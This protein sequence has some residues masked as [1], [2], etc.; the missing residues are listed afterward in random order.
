MLSLKHVKKSFSEPNGQR[1]HI[2]D[3][4]AYELGA[5]EQ[6]ALVGR[7]GCGKTTLLHIIA[8]ISRP[9]SGTCSLPGLDR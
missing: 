7:S 4:D 5:G 8:G 3:I 9:D 1:L 2:L 6:A